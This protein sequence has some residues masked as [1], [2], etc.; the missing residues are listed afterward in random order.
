M[1]I[2]CQRLC[3]S[4]AYIS[5]TKI[6]VNSGTFENLCYAYHIKI[7]GKETVYSKA[8]HDA[9]FMRLKCDYMGNAI[10]SNV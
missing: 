3:E 10:S 8:D 6:E 1:Y 2:F 4:A 7:C 5:G 9:A